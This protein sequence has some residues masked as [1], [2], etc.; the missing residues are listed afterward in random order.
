MLLAVFSDFPSIPLFWGVLVD[1]MSLDS[2]TA[3]ILLYNIHWNWQIEVKKTPSKKMRSQTC[4]CQKTGLI[5]P[6]HMMALCV[7]GVITLSSNSWDVLHPLGACEIF[8]K[9]LEQL[10]KE[11]SVL[12][13]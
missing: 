6:S 4:S 9:L 13:V 11:C 7:Y 12:H 10:C 3:Q 8:A 2:L 1:P 5:N